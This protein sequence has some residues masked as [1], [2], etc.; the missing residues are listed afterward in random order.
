M[1]TLTTSGVKITIKTKYSTEASLP[2]KNHYVFSYL[3]RIENMTEFDVQL[4][5]R[6]WEIYDSDGSYREIEGKGVIGFQPVI[7]PGQVHEYASGC[8]LKMDMGR[9]RGFYTFQKLDNGE[10]FKVQIPDFQLISPYRLN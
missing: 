1:I 3:V 6:H 7:E 5:Y 2:F 10:Q 4:L 9:M 8:H